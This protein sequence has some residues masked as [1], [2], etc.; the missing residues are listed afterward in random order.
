MDDVNGGDEWC[1]S[2]SKFCDSGF[3]MNDVPPARDTRSTKIEDYEVSIVH[4]Q[5][6]HPLDVQP[7]YE[8]VVASQR[9]N[10]PIQANDAN[11]CETLHIVEL[12]NEPCLVRSY[13]RYCIFTA[14]KKP[15]ICVAQLCDQEWTIKLPLVKTEAKLVAEGS[16][17]WH[18]LGPRVA[19]RCVE[20]NEESL[21]IW[22]IER[23]LNRALSFIEYV[24]WVKHRAPIYALGE[25]GHEKDHESVFNQKFG[26]KQEKKRGNEHQYERY[27]HR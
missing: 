17:M 19:S 13:G 4:Y 15:L 24:N 8:H 11:S 3:L 1:C 5:D 18:F 27:S 23:S 9:S 21:R 6:A 26:P 25:K 12:E 2:S 14:A 22:V 16:S 10:A 7:R 20:L